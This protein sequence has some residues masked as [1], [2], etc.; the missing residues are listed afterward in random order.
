M[1]LLLGVDLGTQ[2][3]KAVLHSED[4][5][6]LAESFV[7]SQP[8]HPAPGAV[9]ED[10]AD[11]LASVIATIRDCL[12]KMESGMAPIIDSEFALGDFERGLDRLEGRQVFGR[13]SGRVDRGGGGAH[14]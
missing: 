1:R 13:G 9:E 10:P 5:A 11:Q 7:R 12:A 6:C 14:G 3:T 8:R 2:G 4:G